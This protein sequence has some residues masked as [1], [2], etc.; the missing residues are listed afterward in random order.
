MFPRRSDTKGGICCLCSHQNYLTLVHNF[1]YFAVLEYA[2]LLKETRNW[3]TEYA[4]IKVLSM[5][6][7]LSSAELFIECFDGGF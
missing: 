1:K 5:I 7:C 2:Q 3:H 4:R 6:M